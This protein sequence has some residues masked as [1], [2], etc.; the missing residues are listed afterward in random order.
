ML[1]CL[2]R[3]EHGDASPGKTMLEILA[4]KQATLVV[5]GHGKDQ[6]VPDRHLVIRREIQCRAHCVER[7]IGDLERIRPTQ[8]GRPCIRRGAAGFA[9]KNAVQFPKCLDRATTRCP[10]KRATSSRAALQRRASPA[11]SA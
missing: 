3:I 6:R 11:P 2:E 7:G 1:R 8:D 10:G 9:D 4:E 5:R